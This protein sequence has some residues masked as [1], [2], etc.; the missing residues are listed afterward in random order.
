MRIKQQRE[1]IE[2]AP[3]GKKR[4]TPRNH[5]AETVSVKQ[6]LQ[7]NT[8][9]QSVAEYTELFISPPRKMLRVNTRKD[10]ENPA[11]KVNVLLSK[12]QLNKNNEV[13]CVQG[14]WKKNLLLDL[15]V[16]WE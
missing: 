7:P 16:T 5:V 2:S 4:K 1:E 11:G 14:Q 9:Q 8:N 12:M 13:Q 15:S 10:D 6:S 3:V